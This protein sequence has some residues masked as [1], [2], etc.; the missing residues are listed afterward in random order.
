[1]QSPGA[2]QSAT[3]RHDPLV[4]FDN[5]EASARLVPSSRLH[6]LDRADQM[7]F[8]ADTWHGI[9]EVLAGHIH[10]AG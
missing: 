7:F 2:M 5:G 9:A 3:V 10:A 6:R 1:M 4:P 8:N